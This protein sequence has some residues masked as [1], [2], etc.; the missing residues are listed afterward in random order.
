MIETL[1]GRLQAR[2]AE[3]LLDQAKRELT[4]SKPQT[5]WRLLL[6]KALA[7]AILATP[8]FMIFVGVVIIAPNLTNLFSILIGLI[9]IAF[10][11]VIFPRRPKNEARTYRRKDIPEFFGFLDEVSQ[12]LNTEP[13]N[14]VQFDG[15]VNAF[16]AQYK[17]GF[18][19][20]EEWVLG[21]GFPLW[22]ALQPRERIALVAHELAHK[23]NDDPA[24]QGLF[25][26]AN[27][28]LHNWI[29][30]LQPN[31]RYCFEDRFYNEFS[32]PIFNSIAVGIVEAFRAILARLSF[33]ESQRAEYRADAY[34]ARV[35]GVASSIGILK[36]LTRLE[37]AERAVLDLY[38][39]NRE[40]NGRIFDHMGAAVANAEEE[41][42]EKLFNQAANEKRAVDSSHPPTLLRI[43]FLESL[44]NSDEPAELDPSLVDFVAI[45]EEL[46][47]IKDELGREMMEY[48]HA[49]EVNR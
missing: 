18:L 49:I 25:A 5:T 8:Y 15:D 2:H 32:I 40:Q 20:D 48:L 7:T 6:A 42:A 39:Y 9:L 24:R 3:Q 4:H 19:R 10:G 21:I 27:I 14:G 28:V 17:Y 22:E 12:R 41:L 47:P 35:S 38:P 30:T 36:R 1:I 37:L 26:S 23:V 46:R 29:E 33:F 16:M 13:P 44:P 34:G 11:I 43:E 45:D 31:D